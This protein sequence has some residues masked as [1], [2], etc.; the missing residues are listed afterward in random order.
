MAWNSKAAKSALI[1][2]LGLDEKKVPIGAPIAGSYGLVSDSSHGAYKDGWDIERAYKDGVSKITWVWR[3]IDAI[4]SNQAKLPMILR[5]DNQFDGEIVT[6]APVL[7]L[8]NNRANVGESAWDFRYRLSSQL[9]MSTRG[10]F[11]EVVRGNGGVPVS[12][13]LLPPQYTSPI[14]DQKT[15][16]KGFL[17]E[18]PSQHGGNPTKITMKPE[19]VI[20]VR[21]PHPLD[22]Y[23][24][25]TPMEA[26]GIAI[27]IEMLAK[28]YNRNFLINDGRPGGLLVIR[29]DME[30]EDKEELRSRFRGNIS[31][32]GSVGVISSEDGADF[33][34]TA[35]SPREAAYVQMRD[36]T[37][38]EILAA[39]GVP[40]SILGNASGR[41]FAN[42][43]EEGRVFWSET[44]DP[45]LKLI[46]SS[47]YALDAQHF[48]DFDKSSVPI[49][50]VAKQERD[51]Y[52][53]E[54]KAA[55]VISANEYREIS[56]RKKVESELADAL[57]ANPNLTPIGNTEKATPSPSTGLEAG[58][59]LDSQTTAG[60]QEPST[61]FNPETGTF[62][63]TADGDGDAARQEG[64]LSIELPAS[65]VPSELNDEEAGDPGGPLVKGQKSPTTVGTLTTTK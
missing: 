63:T 5:K 15:F 12:L 31:R 60:Q 11:I 61:Q 57:L 3:S 20:W 23:L 56:G 44:M 41:T 29:S 54:E 26:A 48:L 2:R 10:V 6:N 53:L 7:N 28:M 52:A 25:M 14:P 13:N 58:A 17:V 27:E 43:A 62:E 50:I 49:L 22:P 38:D 42:A 39:F 55:G 19:D 35:A 65:S 24:S 30:D 40:E 32:T 18:L 45:H 64:T 4:A 59:S 9:L 51:G 46:S 34:D 47:A 37:K 36:L 16:V 33:V 8:L 1:N 21:R